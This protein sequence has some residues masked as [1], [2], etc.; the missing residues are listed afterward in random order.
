MKI[1]NL[2][3]GAGSAGI[4]IASGLTKTGKNVVLVSQTIGGDCTHTGCVPSKRF[5]FLA[6]QYTK[7]TSIQKK[8]F[9]KMHFKIFDLP[10]KELKS[11]IKCFLKKQ[12]Y[13]LFKDQQNLR[14]E[15]QFQ[16]KILKKGFR[17]FSLKSVILRLEALH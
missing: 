13:H 1:D 9:I 12:Q 14:E 5:L 15:I 17:Q 10:S 4:T 6:K 3:V 11:M 2:V 7:A 8:I 16:Y